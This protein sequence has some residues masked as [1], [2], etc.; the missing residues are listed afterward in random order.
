MM[1]PP[2]SWQDAYGYQ[3]PT[4]QDPNSNWFLV[5]VGDHRVRAGGPTKRRSSGLFLSITKD[6][7]QW[8]R[9]GL[10]AMVTWM[11]AFQVV[12]EISLKSVEA[13]VIRG[14]GYQLR[15]AR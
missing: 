13:R 11:R 8:W 12:K 9:Y 6:T 7:L 15:E 1:S 14:G 3:P 2:T 5:P 4:C 10:Q